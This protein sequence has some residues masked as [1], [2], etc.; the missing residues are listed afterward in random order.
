MFG[1][2][3]V[4]AAIRPAA[5]TADRD[6]RG[7]RSPY[8]RHPRGR[9]L[10]GQGYP[11]K[12]AADFHHRARL[13]RCGHREARGDALGAFDEQIDCRRVDS[14]ADIQRGHRPHLFLGDSESLSTGGQDP[15]GRRLRDDRLDLV[16]DSV[17][18]VFAVIENQQPD[19]AFQ[20]GGHRLGYGLA[21]L[22]VDAQHCRH[23]VGYS[24]RVGNGGQFENPDPVREL[25]G[26][27][28]RN[29]QR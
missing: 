18:H 23:G 5:G 28:R 13:I 2:V 10:D 3:P 12:A 1:G 22:L 11:V 8:R 19:S 21:G 26:Q 15:H 24:C 25:V 17:E 9:Q 14:I 29:L 6:G 27:T 20:C 16:G 4:R 7:P